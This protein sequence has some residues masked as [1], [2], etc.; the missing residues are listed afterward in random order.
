[1]KIAITVKPNTKRSGLEQLADDSYRVAVKSPPV[2]GKANAEVIEALAK[3]F[4]VPKS[5]VR[6]T[7]GAAGRKKWVEIG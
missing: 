2:D 5:A 7:R 4:R 1:M 6:I 3:H